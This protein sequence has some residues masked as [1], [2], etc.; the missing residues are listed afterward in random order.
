MFSKKLV[1]LTVPCFFFLALACVE[2][3]IILAD[4]WSSI[5][6]VTLSMNCEV[7]CSSSLLLLANLREDAFESRSPLLSKK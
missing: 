2:V 5:L 1:G 3:S 6:L 7:V 4:S